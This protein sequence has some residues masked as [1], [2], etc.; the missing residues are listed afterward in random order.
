MKVTFKL[1]GAEDLDALVET[2]YRQINEMRATL[3]KIGQVTLELE[4][5]V[6]QPPADT[7]G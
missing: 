2:L 3:N 4:A 7:S 6:N 1:K 5:E